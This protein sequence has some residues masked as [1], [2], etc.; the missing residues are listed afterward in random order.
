MVG[1]VVFFLNPALACLVDDGDDFQ[2]GANEMRAAVEGSW[3]A[4]LTSAD[5]T[6][7]TV[8]FNLMQGTGPGTV[9]AGRADKARRSAAALLVRPAAACG[10]RQLVRGAAACASSSSMPLEG[11][12]VSGDPVYS[13]APMRGRFVIWGLAFTS[14]A[15]EV[16]L[17][18][19]GT[20]GLLFNL[21]PAGET[22]NV[23]VVA[24]QTSNVMVGATAALVRLSR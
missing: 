24:P 19:N 12:F 1:S 14:G 3:E 9:T 8:I 6:P 7:S 23:R 18:L 5:G 16:S 4:S 11:T 13:A 17:T 20:V 22:S 21:S 10:E 2:Y 15:T